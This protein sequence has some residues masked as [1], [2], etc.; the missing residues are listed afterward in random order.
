M[1]TILCSPQKKWNTWT[2]E[3]WESDKVSFAA[4]SDD[5]VTG[6]Y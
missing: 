5:F 2:Y 3:F 6:S 1:I 4:P